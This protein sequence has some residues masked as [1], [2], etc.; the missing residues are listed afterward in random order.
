MPTEAFESPK[1]QAKTLA[2]IGQANRIIAEYQALGFVL[3]LRQLY[4]QFVSR[5]AIANTLAEYKRLGTII[6][7]GRRAGLIDWDAIEDRTSNVRRQPSW[8]NPSEIIEAVSRQYRED[9]WAGQYFRPE[10]WIE[11]D[12]LLGVIENVCEE[13]RVPYFACRGN[14]SE[15][16][17]YKAGRRFA[18]YRD[19]GL[20]PLVLHLGDHDPNGIDMTRDNRDR[21][22]LFARGDV[23]VRRIAL[24][25]D[26]VELYR[27]PP[28]PAKEN[29]TRFAAYARRFGAQ[30]WELDALDPSVIAG[31]IRAEIEG[32]IDA[33]AWEEAKARE[34]ENRDVLGE[35]SQNWALF[36]NFLR[37]GPP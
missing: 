3:T 13:Y 12:A 30:C 23:E 16:E 5:A 7:S 31:L 10:V 22:A 18:D 8:S 33:E 34:E 35:A 14:N 36:E 9:L 6:R 28:N 25:L 1:L 19:E 21:L 11:K 37:Q 15:S 27:P 2:V 20:T 4:Y 29:D 26:Q 24:N 17:Q 32:L